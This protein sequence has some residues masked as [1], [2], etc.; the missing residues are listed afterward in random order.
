MSTF[1]QM[2]G[3]CVADGYLANHARTKDE[4]FPVKKTT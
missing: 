2:L 4:G 1:W 3:E